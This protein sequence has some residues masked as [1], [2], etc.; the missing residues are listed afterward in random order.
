MNVFEINQGYFKV[1]DGHTAYIYHV[2]ED[3][4]YDNLRQPEVWYWYAQRKGL[5]ESE[6]IDLMLQMLHVRR[7]T[8]VKW[9]KALSLCVAL[10]GSRGSGKSV[11]A[12]QIA[13]VDGL[14]AG[15]RVVSNM[16]IAIKVRYK[17]CEKVFEAEDLDTV[18]LLNQNEFFENYQDAMIVVDETNMSVAD[19]Q[20]STSNQALF[21]GDILQQMRK[22]QL[23]FIFTTQSEAFQTNRVRFQTDIYIAC[24]DLAMVAGDGDS[25]IDPDPDQLGRKSLWRLY[26]MSGLIMGE[27]LKVNDLRTDRVRY[28]D[29]KIVWNTPFWNC[30]SNELMQRREKY[31]LQVQDKA[32]EV[33]FDA[34]HMA[35]IA[36]KYKMP[37]DLI[38]QAVNLGISSMIKA[39][40]WELLGVSGNRSMQTKLGT[41]L[42]KLGC[43]TFETTSGKGYNFPTQAEMLKRLSKMGLNAINMEGEND[44]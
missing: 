35:L 5:S 41:I 40:L 3:H 33:G 22:R 23:D 26:D 42:K 13:V 17:D 20:R 28:Y 27:V 24:R 4:N 25:F 37:A 29:E 43:R 19:A 31:K 39:D 1:Y 44:N 15:R 9:L 16:P 34:A 7:I 6:T 14:L 2:N 12:T 32:Q 18:M 36:E 30:Y 10:I 8:K 11:G 38:K 21:F